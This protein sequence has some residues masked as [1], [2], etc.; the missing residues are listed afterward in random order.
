MST[1]PI[2]ICLECGAPFEKH[3]SHHYR[4][5]NRCNVA[6]H[7]KKKA[8]NKVVELSTVEQ[9]KQLVQSLADDVASLKRYNPAQPLTSHQ[10]L[11]NEE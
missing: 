1:H 5:S 4:C 10:Q 2:A 8:A 11:S 6:N 9:L 3:T 7:R